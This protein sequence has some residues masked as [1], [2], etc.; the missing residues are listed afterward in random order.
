[1]NILAF[2]VRVNGPKFDPAFAIGSIGQPYS[3][4]RNRSWR[5]LI[6][7]HPN[8]RYRVVESID[9]PLKYRQ[10]SDIAISALHPRHRLIK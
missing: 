10:A 7:R 8:Y 2:D 1:M 3:T 4:F 6:S 9:C 5:L